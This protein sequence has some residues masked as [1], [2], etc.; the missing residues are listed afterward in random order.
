MQHCSPSWNKW[1]VRWMVRWNTPPIQ[2]KPTGNPTG[3]PTRS[4]GVLLSEAYIAF[5]Y[6]VERCIRFGLPVSLRLS[7][8]YYIEIIQ[9]HKPNLIVQI[10][11]RDGDKGDKAETLCLG[12]T[13]PS[14]WARACYRT[15]NG[16]NWIP[17]PSYSLYNIASAASSPAIKKSEFEPY[18]PLK[19]YKN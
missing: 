6:G 19:I 5:I 7:T 3:I 1:E 15:C 10:P 4:N 11:H 9:Q 12:E 17:K 2:R 16:S 8:H 18:D 14:N 13:F